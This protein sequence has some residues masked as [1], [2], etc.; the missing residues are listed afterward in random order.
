M[1]IFSHQSLIYD[2]FKKIRINIIFIF[3]KPKLNEF[4]VNLLKKS[5]SVF[6]S[7]KYIGKLYFWAKSKWNGN[8][9]NQL[10]EKILKN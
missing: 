2:F 9:L 1:S 3:E 6:L 4:F 7:C 5:P 8:Y 10:I